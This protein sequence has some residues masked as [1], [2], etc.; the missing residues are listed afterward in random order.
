MATKAIDECFSVDKTLHQGRQTASQFLLPCYTLIL[1][2]VATV[3]QKY[4]SVQNTHCKQLEKP[5]V[6]E[7]KSNF[8]ARL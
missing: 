3:D 5:A 4:K 2:Y 8:M 6:R 1:K 7:N